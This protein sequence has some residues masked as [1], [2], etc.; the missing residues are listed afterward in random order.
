MN[1]KAKEREARLFLNVRGREKALRRL[2]SESEEPSIP[3]RSCLSTE[4]QVPQEAAPAATA[5]QVGRGWASCTSVALRSLLI[6]TTAGSRWG[7]CPRRLRPRHQEHSAQAASQAGTRRRD[8]WPRAQ[9]GGGG[10]EPACA[11]PPG[12]LP[13]PWLRGEGRGAQSASPL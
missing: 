5:R 1:I 13:D 4:A 7:P 9:R 12:G 6:K 10:G 2:G 3:K 11:L 8:G